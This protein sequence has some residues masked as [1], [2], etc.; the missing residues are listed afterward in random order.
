MDC[1]NVPDGIYRDPQLQCS[2]NF[3]FCANNVSFRGVCPADLYFDAGRKTCDYW[4]YIFDCSSLI[5]ILP[6][7]Q[8]RL[9]DKGH[10]GKSEFLYS[11][12]MCQL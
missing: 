3:Y 6:R 4:I 7:T 12:Q 8:E 9:S 10:D 11:F 1:V 5:M 2:R